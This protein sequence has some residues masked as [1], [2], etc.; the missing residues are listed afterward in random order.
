MYTLATRRSEQLALGSP[1]E[2]RTLARRIYIYIALLF[3][4]VTIIV[5]VVQI[6]RLALGLALGASEAGALGELGRWIGYALIGGVIGY[7]Y[8]TLVRRAGEANEETMSVTATLIMDAPLSTIIAG[9]VQRDLVVGGLACGFARRYSGN[10]PSITGADVLVT[11]LPAL[12]TG[13]N[14]P[15]FDAFDGHRILL[16]ISIDRYDVVG[17]MHSD[18]EWAHETVPA[19][20]EYAKQMPMATN[21]QPDG[22]CNLPEDTKETNPSDDPST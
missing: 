7:Y 18:D 17:A 11:T 9:R 6:I 21:E 19:L 20:R 1:I 13:L 5:A 10:Y 14:V 2:E 8:F 12:L 16:P 15:A 22:D 4:I 3:G